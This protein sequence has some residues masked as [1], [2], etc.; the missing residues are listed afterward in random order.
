MGWINSEEIKLAVS[1]KQIRFP[2]GG[3]FELSAL[4]DEEGVEEAQPD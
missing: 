4:E 3:S 2:G 1:G